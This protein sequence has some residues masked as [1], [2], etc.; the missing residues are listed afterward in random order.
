MA[1]WLTLLF[2]KSKAIPGVKVGENRAAAEASILTHGTSMNQIRFAAMVLL[3]T[4]AGAAEAQKLQP[5]KPSF[6]NA[7]KALTKF[8]ARIPASGSVALHIQILLD[9]AYFSP[10]IIDGAWGANAARA[11]AF[12]SNP[13]GN[14]RLKGG[15]PATS[16]S[17]DGETYA[18]LRGAAG[19]RA[20]LTRYTITK[21]DVGGPFTPIPELVYDQAK[22]KCLCYASP[23]ELIA[24]RFHTS[25]QLLAQLNPKVRIDK[26]TAGTELVVPNVARENVAT[27]MDTVLVAKLIISK[28]GFWTHAVDAGGTILAHYPSTLGGGYDPSPDGKLR[29]THVARDPAFR[30]QPKLFAE[31]PDDKPEALLPPGPNSPVGRVW[32]SLSKPHYGIHGTSTPETIGYA[33]SHGCVRLT[34]WSALEL[35]ELVEPGTPV[36]FH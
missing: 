3:V 34:N 24:E 11:L 36:E 9:R 13:H 7:E 27:A 32:M 10:G 4:I 29:V 1:L 19:E 26:L 14:E 28:T 17:I 16:Q 8:P 18:R 35:S 6:E 15:T 23:A 21:A 30:Y 5:G 31:V 2:T 33:T 22:L 20:L 25:Q 12:Y